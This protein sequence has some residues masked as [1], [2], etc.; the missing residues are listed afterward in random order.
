MPE[1]DLPTSPTRSAA[2]IERLTSW[3]AVTA[4]SPRPCTTVTERQTASSACAAA[5]LT[6]APTVA[7]LDDPVGRASDPRG[8]SDHDDGAL[9]FRAQL[10]ERV[11][12]EPLVGGVELTG[13]L[14]CEHEWRAAR[15]RGGDRDPLLLATGQRAGSLP[16][17]PPESERIERGL[18]GGA[19]IRVARE[20]QR[21]SHVLTRRQA[22]PQVVSLE[23]ER[24]L[25]G[26]VPR[27]PDFVEQ[28]ER[29][30]AGADFTGRGL[31]ERRRQRQHRALAAAGGAEHGDQL[32]TLDA[33]LQAAQRNGL[34]R[35][36]PKDLEN[37]V[38]LQCR[39]G[40]LLLGQLRLDVQ[41]PDLVGGTQGVQCQLK[42]LII[43]RYASTLS[44]PL[45]VPR[46]TVARLPPPAS[47]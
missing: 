39:P 6:G 17:A 30:L 32:A 36:R 26:A 11:E 27:K 1:P 14:V 44:T 37:V 45:A 40:D 43:L 8:V 9:E 21:D 29:V 47:S 7:Q 46:S 41:A 16:A 42:L 24:D 20:L 3:S 5:V 38:E 4:A 15:G 28:P 25:P 22:G 18:S 34:D 2:P 35:A 19:R 12:H 31:V 10:R 13:R 33:E 23:H